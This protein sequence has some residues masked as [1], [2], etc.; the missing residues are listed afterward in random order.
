M[1]RSV[2]EELSESEWFT[3]VAIGTR[4]PLA[5]E[6]CTQGTL[7]QHRPDRKH[8]FSDFKAIKF[9]TIAFNPERLKNVHGNYC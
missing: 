8:M 7:R 2:L 4:R 3:V 9:Q 6:G 5:V 1:K